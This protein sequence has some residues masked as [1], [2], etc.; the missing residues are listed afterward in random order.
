M[1]NTKFAAL[2]TV[3][4]SL[5]LAAP[6]L[7][8]PASDQYAEGLKL[9][10]A[11]KID[12]AIAA[13]E[14][15][16]KVR[17]D[18][19]AVHQ[20]VGVLYRKKGNFSK[21][22]VHV[23]RAIKF[24]P[25]WANAHYSLGLILHHQ[26]RKDE[27]IAAMEQAAKLDPKDPMAP[28]QLGVMLGRKDPKKAVVYL[29][30]AAK[31]KPGDWRVV[32]KLGIAHRRAGQ[33]KEAEAALLL[34]ANNSLTANLAF[35]LGVMFRHKKE[36]R[37]AVLYYKKAIK[38]DP[39]MTDAHWDLAHMYDLLNEEANAKKSYEVFLTLK[40]EGKQAEVARARL[41]ALKK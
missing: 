15:A 34:A 5:L 33:L 1:S 19:A 12:E 24:Q 13:M 10:K 32:H 16:L 3:S 29:K 22:E 37:K 30:K 7:A 26:G 28:E 25:K 38:L 35:D 6:A 18:Y 39:K 31:L 41:E 2:F 20:S 36:P 23:R 27:A 40:K 17:P 4:V 11:G 14:R 21:A 8:G 9:K